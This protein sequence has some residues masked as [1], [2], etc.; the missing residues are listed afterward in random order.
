M[1]EQFLDAVGA[2]SSYVVLCIEWMMANIAVW[3][4]RD[5]C[6]GWTG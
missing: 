6:K 3:A 4:V 1:H 5:V 2:V